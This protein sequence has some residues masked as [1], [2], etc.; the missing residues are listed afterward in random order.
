MLCRFRR[1]MVWGLGFRKSY[2]GGL[3][4]LLH[5]VLIVALELGSSHA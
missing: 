3:F 1:S 5:E 4:V 2:A